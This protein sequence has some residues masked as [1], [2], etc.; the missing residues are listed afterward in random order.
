MNYFNADIKSCDKLAFE[1]DLVFKY[2]TKEEFNKLNY[3]KFSI[4]R[5]ELS[6]IVVTATDSIIQLLSEF[7]SANLLEL[8][9]RRI[10]VLSIKG[11]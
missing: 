7:K 3:L 10:H 2:L 1:I 6:N 5:Q 9:G 8:N 4:T 11:L